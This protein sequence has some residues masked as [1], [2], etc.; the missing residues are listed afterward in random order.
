MLIKYYKQD[1]LLYL[2]LKNIVWI[3]NFMSEIVY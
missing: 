1:N 3:E 2:K